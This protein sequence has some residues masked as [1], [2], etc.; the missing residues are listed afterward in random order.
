MLIAFHMSLLFYAST[1]TPPD[2]R[3]QS[4]NYHVL[5][6]GAAAPAV[7]RALR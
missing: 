5:G 7:F 2:F 1:H 4:S 6:L 3:M